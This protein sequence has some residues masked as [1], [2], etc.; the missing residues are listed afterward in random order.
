[1]FRGARA[2][3]GAA[4]CAVAL[5][6]APGAAQAEVR[7]VYDAWFSA[8]LLY[9]TTEASENG[10][11]TR[12]TTS[13]IGVTGWLYGL[14]F[15][16]R[17]LI[18][19]RAAETLRILYSEADSHYVNGDDSPPDVNDCN[20]DSLTIG[21]AGVANPL[22]VFDPN[23][24]PTTIGFTPVVAAA[25]AQTCTFGTGRFTLGIQPHT[26]GY[27]GADHL[28]AEIV[29]PQDQLGD[30]KIDLKFGRVRNTPRRCPGTFV[31]PDLRTCKTVLTGRM[32]LYSTYVDEGDELL[33]PPPAPAQRP[34]VDRGARRAR[35]T[36]RCPSGCRYRIRIFLAPRAGRGRLGEGSAA[37]AGPRANA[38]VAETVIASASGRL[39][40]GRAVRTIDVA[41][42][43]A[44]RAEVIEAGGALVELSL[45]PP[46]GRTVT[47]TSF[48][49]A[50]G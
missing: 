49:R 4:A 12:S 20:D 10:R 22:R 25:F 24:G 39:P 37:T 48:A 47:S 17:R 36:A 34:T 5:A 29:V 46:R 2:L 35:A 18:T 1:M 28:R 32:R 41:I 31:E 40:A 26:P 11:V 13:R 45:D 50:R 15:I 9:D 16:E 42:P 23:A 33:A 27:L 7:H 6:A 21:L 43:A 19:Q 14:K 44:K 8:E 3:T 30:D 38:A